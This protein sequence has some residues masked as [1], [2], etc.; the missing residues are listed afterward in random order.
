[1]R[2]L[3]PEIAEKRWIDIWDHRRDA[4][5]RTFVDLEGARGSVGRGDYN[6]RWN[7]QVVQGLIELG[8]LKREQF[9][10]EDLRELL[11][12][13]DVEVSDWTAVSRAAARLGA[14]TFWHD[15][16]GPWQRREMDGFSESLNRVR[17]VSLLRVGACSGIAA[18]Y[19]PNEELRRNW[20]SRLE[21]MQPVG[22]CGRCP[23]CRRT[24]VPL[25]A[26]PPPSP[27]QDWAV[28]MT[29]LSALQTFATAVRGVNGCAFITYRNGED[30]LAVRIGTSLAMLGVRHFGGL[31]APVKAQQGE[32][33]FFDQSPLS[34]ADLTPVS[35]F[36]YFEP[37]RT[38]SR[39][40]LARREVGRVNANRD[41]LVDILLVPNGTSIGGRSVGKD[42]PSVSAATALELSRRS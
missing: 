9:D 36:S 35:S 30:D 37:T 14:P 4:S 2:V 16:W 38:V 15:V 20:G 21:F 19:A 24:D 11:N 42:I 3:S 18:A 22:S 40:W 41:E 32:A 5:G 23:D 10:V 1:V 31:P 26:D 28:Y 8:E 17:D 7:A 33:I 27:K 13:D 6:R 25:Y 12:K 34:P 29:D 39:R